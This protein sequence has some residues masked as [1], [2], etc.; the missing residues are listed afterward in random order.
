[1]KVCESPVQGAVCRIRP[2]GEKPPGLAKANGAFHIGHG[3]SSIKARLCHMV[4]E[5]FLIID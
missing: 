4:F 3:I 1:V 5:L 2:Q